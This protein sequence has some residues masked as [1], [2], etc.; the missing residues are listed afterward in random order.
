MQTEAARELVWLRS[1]IE[2]IGSLWYGF[3]ISDQGS[4]DE[5]YVKIEQGYVSKLLLT[6]Y[7]VTQAKAVKIATFEAKTVVK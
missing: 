1:T 6:P 7:T 4:T 5:R 3:E 2:S